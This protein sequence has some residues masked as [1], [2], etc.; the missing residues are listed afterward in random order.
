MGINDLP[1]AGINFR[2]TSGAGN[3]KK[4]LSNATRSGD[5]KN[6]RDNQKAIVEV[7]KKYQS[8]I[9]IKGGLSRLQQRD[10]WLKVKKSTPKLTYAD[11]YETKEIFKHLGRGASDNEKKPAVAGKEIKGSGGKSVFL[12]DEQIRK[13]LFRNRDRDESW[14]GGKGETYKKRYAGGEV[15]SYGVRGDTRHTMKDIGIDRERAGKIGFAGNYQNNKLPDSAAPKMPSGGIK[16][17][18]LMNN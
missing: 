9:R 10:A 6:L 5:L 2:A 1:R 17:I 18:G 13:N 12:T 14:T 11:K 7:V 3:F 15:E 4:R 16:P 8:V